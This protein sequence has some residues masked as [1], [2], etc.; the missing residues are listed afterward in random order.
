M[1]VGAGGGFGWGEGEG[2]EEGGRGHGV[3]GRGDG[4][5]AVGGGGGGGGKCG[6]GSGVVAAETLGVGFPEE[7]DGFMGG[8]KFQPELRVG[9]I[10]VVVDGCIAR[11]RRRC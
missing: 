1:E 8:A 6:V 3:E 10:F 9:D 4:A 2:E 5:A 7:G 11:A